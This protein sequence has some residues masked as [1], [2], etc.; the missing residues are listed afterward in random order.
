MFRALSLTT[1]LTLFFTL[2]VT[3]AGAGLA[4]L[5]VAESERHFVEL[6]RAELQDKQRQLRELLQQATSRADSV[7]LLREILAQHRGLAASVSDGRGEILFR[8]ADFQQPRETVANTGAPALFEWTEHSRQ[9]RGIRFRIPPGAAGE[10]LNVVLAVDTA[11][12]ARFMQT[13]R[14]SLTI[15]VVAM[16]AICAVLGWLAAYRGLA[17]LR[18]MKSRLTALTSRQLHHR[19]PVDAVPVEMARLA[20]ELNQMLDRL[21]DAFKRLSAFSA[22]LAHELRTP[23]S[24]LL[25]Q[26]QVALVNR[27]DADTY[28]DI[29]ASNAE[30]LHRLNRMVADMLFL[31]KAE[32]GDMLPH[33]ER[34]A[35]AAEVHAL[36][37]F[38]EALAEEKQVAL[39]REGEGEIFGDRLMFRRALSNLLSNALR[40]TPAGGEITVSI[41]NGPELTRVRVANT[42]ADIDP[43][44]LPRLFDR[45]F[46]ASQAQTEG[47]GLGLAIT[48]AIMQAHGGAIE[49]RSAGGSTVFS[50]DFPGAPR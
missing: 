10:N 31:A 47:A 46:R 27:R 9:L 39:R 30:E 19:M 15:Y 18:A 49:V 28:R 37:E 20:R 12:H 40:H 34:F 38:Y 6:D 33:R 3:L 16:L 25:T 5:V 13:L 2:S 24:N 1:R 45:F 36:F 22:D 21:E 7:R 29:L 11:T 32:R 41:E 43:A 8:S 4:W 23:L 50:L 42:G 48:R 44:A 35:A 14:R 17:P 26:T